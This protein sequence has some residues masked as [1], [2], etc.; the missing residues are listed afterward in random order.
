MTPIRHAVAAACACAAAF[1]G[2]AAAQTASAPTLSVTI[3]GI[4]DACVARSSL[5]NSS[6]SLL[7]GG[8]LFGSRLGFRGQ[9]DLGG[10]MQAYFQLEQG[11]NAD[12]GTLGQNGRGFGRKSIVA[13]RGG[14]GAVELGRDYAPAFYIVQPV[15]PMGLGVGS[16]SSTIWTGAPSTTAARVD[17][18]VNYL[19]PTF[20]GFSARLQVAP[21]EQAAPN[22]SRGGDVKGLN[23][24][25]RSGKTLLGLSHARV[26]NPAAT[27]D[28]SATTLVAQHG[29]GGVTLAAMVQSGAWKGSR[30]VAAPSS[31]SSIFSRDYRSYLLGAS[32]QAGVGTVN[33]SWK[34]YDDRTAANFDATQWSLN[35]VYPL[36]KRTQLYGAYTRLKNRNGS[37]YGVAD[38]SGT[39]GGVTPGASTSLLAAGIRHAF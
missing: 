15:D 33:V 28:D 11:F 20:G 17:N 36:S 14:A 2:H 12:S 32:V 38:A 39:Y 25:Y 9:E 19:S 6:M 37:S 16:A 24:V 13:L 7:G 8:C 21:G 3:Y 31:A 27:A 23:L 5:G 34:Q 35:Y 4:V 22:A 18:A 10:G 1:A 29:I 30:T 26:R